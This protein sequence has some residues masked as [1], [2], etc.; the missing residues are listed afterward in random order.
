MA[1]D[2]PEVGSEPNSVFS[3]PYDI[4]EFYIELSFAISSTIFIGKL[5]PWLP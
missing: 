3:Q 2:K 1:F 4:T 5:L